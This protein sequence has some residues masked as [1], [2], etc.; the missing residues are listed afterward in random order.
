MYIGVARYDFLIPG[1]TSLKDKRKVVKRLMATL[2]GKFNASIA[3]VDF[4]DLRQRSAIGASCVSNS[5]FHARKMLN[6]MERTVRS[7]GTIEVL[8]ASLEVVTPDG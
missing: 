2:Q 7:Q 6:E 8:S 4:S 5:S 1:S 3:E